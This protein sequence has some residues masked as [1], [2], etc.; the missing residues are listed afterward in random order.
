MKQNWLL[1]LA[2]ALALSVAWIGDDGLIAPHPVGDRV[3]ADDA[4]DTIAAGKK[5]KKKGKKDKRSRKRGKKRR[6]IR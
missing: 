1:P 4:T 6:D 5:K 3:A 2:S